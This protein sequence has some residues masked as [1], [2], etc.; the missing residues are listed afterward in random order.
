MNNHRTDLNESVN[1]EVSVEL[2]YLLFCEINW[3]HNWNVNF[4]SNEI[5]LLSVIFF[6]VLTYLFHNSKY[7]YVVITLS[8]GLK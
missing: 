5:S 4:I 2:N 7:L 3:L 1:K 8:I 6:L